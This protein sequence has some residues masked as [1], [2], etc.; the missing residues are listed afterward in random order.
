MIWLQRARPE[1]FSKQTAMIIGNG[2]GGAPIR[3]R[4]KRDTAKKRG[5][6]RKKYTRNDSRRQPQQQQQRRRQRRQQEMKE[7][8]AKGVKVAKASSSTRKRS[9]RKGYQPVLQP[10]LVNRNRYVDSEDDED[11]GDR[12]QKKKK[13]ILLRKRKKFNQTIGSKN[14]YSKEE[15]K[16][17]E[18]YDILGS[19]NFE[20]IRGGII[21]NEKKNVAA[22]N[23]EEEAEEEVVENGNKD[24]QVRR[25]EEEDTDGFEPFNF[26]L[27][28]N[29]PILG[30]QGYDNFD[31]SKNQLTTT[32]T[33]INPKHNTAG[34]RNSFR[35]YFL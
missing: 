34:R 35:N 17:V 30:F 4:V 2:G 13:R 18:K 11:D 24:G 25:E 5:K 26:D 15:S 1:V 9:T 16:Q 6:R 21:D 3:K 12:M 14:R 27:F 33:T 10:S 7:M 20:I 22:V 32:T 19:G 28:A 29:D 8:S 23:G 31:S